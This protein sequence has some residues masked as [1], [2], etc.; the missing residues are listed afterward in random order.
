VDWKNGFLSQI[1][2]LTSFLSQLKNHTY[3]SSWLYALLFLALG[4]SQCRKSIKN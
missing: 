2:Q 3:G 4:S 1:E